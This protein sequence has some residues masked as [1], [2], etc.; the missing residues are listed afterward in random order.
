MTKSRHQADYSR[1]EF[2]KRY[3]ALLP[4]SLFFCTLTSPISSIAEPRPAD[5]IR[6]L[7]G[8]RISTS[9][10]DFFAKKTLEAAHV[11]GAQIAVLDGGRL[12]WSAA[13]G[14]RRREPALPMDRET[15]TW[16]ASITRTR[17]KAASAFP[18]WNAIPILG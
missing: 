7:D 13:Y 14:L 16:A 4:A 10:A 6:R 12:V 3:R 18:S 2:Q 1:R 17:Q 11:T 5:W 15:T 9:E 8:S